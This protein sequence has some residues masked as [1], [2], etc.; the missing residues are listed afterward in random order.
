MMNATADALPNLNEILA[1]A[2]AGLTRLMPPLPANFRF[3]W[4]GI[5]FAARIDATDAGARLRLVGDLGP[6]PFSVEGASARDRLLSLV[7]WGDAIGEC[8][9]V[10]GRRH[11][12]NLLGEAPIATPLNGTAIVTT[13]TNFLLHARPYI[14]LVQEQ[15]LA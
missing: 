9:F 13:A 4:D 15:R 12:L 5:D 8:R 10:I 1:D 2:E 3:T 7:R 14:D 6:V 11:H